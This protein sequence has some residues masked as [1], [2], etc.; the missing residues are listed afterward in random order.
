[1]RK[2]A[3]VTKQKYI[4][5]NKA[6]SERLGFNENSDTKQYAPDK[7]LRELEDGRVIMP[8]TS[9]VFEKCADIIKDLEYEE[10]N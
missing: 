4:E 2:N 1:M 9:L 7:P 6:I 10:R 3:I 5:L 8:I